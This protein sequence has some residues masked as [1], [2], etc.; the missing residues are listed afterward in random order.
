MP[1]FLH[2]LLIPQASLADA[3]VARVRSNRDLAVEVYFEPPPNMDD[4]EEVV[5]IRLYGVVVIK[6]EIA[7]ELGFSVVVFFLPIKNRLNVSITSES[8]SIEIKFA[9]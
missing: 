3:V 5:E 1:P 9:I 4:L 6:A 7:S 2:G 8:S